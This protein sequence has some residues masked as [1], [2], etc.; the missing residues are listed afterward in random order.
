MQVAATPHSYGGSTPKEIRKLAAEC[1]GRVEADGLALKVIPG[2]EILYGENI[3]QRIRAGE[4]QCYGETKSV[5]IETS[6]F[7]HPLEFEGSLLKLIRAGY[8]VVLAHPEKLNAVNEDPDVLLPM[9]R[10]GVLMQIT[11]SNLVGIHGELKQSLTKTLIM[12]GMAHLIASDA[13]GATGTRI[14]AMRQA[15]EVAGEILGQKARD[16]FH[17]APAAI[18]KDLP[19]SGLALD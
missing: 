19:I 4:L 2:T 8:R 10:Q 1:Q 6:A 11:A 13:H 17:T 9:I 16:L 12:R 3:F 7:A 15:F 14:P 5:L 18:V